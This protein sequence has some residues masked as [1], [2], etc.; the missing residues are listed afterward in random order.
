MPEHLF[1][2]VVSQ[3]EPFYQGM[4]IME[5][6]IDAGAKYFFLKLIRVGKRVRCIRDCAADNQSYFAR[7]EE[8]LQRTCDRAS[9]ASVSSRKFRV[10]GR[11][12]ERL[13]RRVRD[14][15][16]VSSESRVLNGRHWSPEAEMVFSIHT[17]DE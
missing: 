17:S 15:Q 2:D 16:R 11:G 1:D 7:A 3:L 14:S 10:I 6:C 12:A 4:A 5:A 13:P 9:N 8:T